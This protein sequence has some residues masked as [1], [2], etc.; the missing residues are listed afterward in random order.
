M[1]IYLL[2][3]CC[4]Y[5]KRKKIT[6]FELNVSTKFMKFG[7]E[8]GFLWLA[9][10]IIYCN[11]FFSEFQR[12]PCWN[13]NNTMNP[14]QLIR[15][16]TN[17]FL[18]FCFEHEF[19]CESISMSIH[20]LSVNSSVVLN[21]LF[22]ITRPVQSKF[23]FSFQNHDPGQSVAPNNFKTSLIGSRQSEFWTMW[24][25]KKPNNNQNWMQLWSDMS[26]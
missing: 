8:F 23:F 2:W 15:F 24:K 12:M 10:E 16:I 19:D 17:L 3:E 7:L 6:L 5:L 4:T 20:Y 18:F 26:T 13:K 14:I 25:R 22:L 21:F 11:G 9:I 1:S